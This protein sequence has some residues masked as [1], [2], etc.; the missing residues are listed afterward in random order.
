MAK[1]LIIV[2]VGIALW[3]SP[4][5]EALG[6]QEWHLF[7]IFITTIFGV[8]FNAFNVL[9]AS[10]LA[11]AITILT[12]TLPAS[13][14]FSGFSEGFIL[15]ILVAFL[16][17]K[18]VVKSGLGTRIALMMISR[19]GYSSLGLGYSLLATDMIIAPAFPSNTARYRS[20]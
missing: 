12:G 2:A 3:F 20:R 11:L 10:V 13:D 4:H 17:A 1:K 9:P 16:I 14:A 18:A 5:P 6:Q 7:A 8:V 15:L 19:F